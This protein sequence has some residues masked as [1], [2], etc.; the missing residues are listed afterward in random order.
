M[1][2]IALAFAALVGFLAPVSAAPPKS[3]VDPDPKS[4]EIPS[5]ELSKAREL[6]R[7]LGSETYAEREAAERELA[8]M[9]RL[10]RPALLNGVN[11]DPDPEIRAR[12]NVLLPKANAEELQARLDAFLADTENKYEHDLP[13]WNKLR[14]VIRGEWKMFGWTCTVR[15]NTDKAARELFLEFIKAPGGQKLLAAFGGPAEELGRAVATRKQDLYNARFVRQPGAAPRTP[16]AIEVVLLVFAESQVNSRHVPKTNYP[17]TSIIQ[18]SGLPP[19]VRGTDERSLAVQAIMNAWFDSRTDPLDQYGALT[20]AN[21]M[22]ND[23]AAGRLASRVLAATGL[24]GFYKT[25]ALSTI[26]RLK[27]RDQIPNLEKVFDDQTVIATT[28]K[29]VNGKV[30]RQSVEA[31]DAAL[32]VAL[33]LTGQEP[34][35]YGFDAFPK[36]A[37][38]TFSPLWAKIADD[39]RQEAFDKWK[40]WREKNP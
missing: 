5:E 12:C 16:T 2:R 9:G 36:N 15:P 23:V 31:R 11:V 3:K 19:I 28:G 29:V 17:L 20:L 35:D 14:A 6:V 27:S 24:Q 13:G 33:I 37:G 26:V 22:Q 10:A 4:L 30:E 40:A 25:Q 7:Q 32:A 18:T 1:L 39:K 38:I 34:S 8:Q 21:S